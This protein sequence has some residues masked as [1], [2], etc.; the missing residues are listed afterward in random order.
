M[1]KKTESVSRTYRVK[2]VSDGSMTISINK[3][4]LENYMGELPVRRI[5]DWAIDSKM[6]DELNAAIHT[7]RELKI[8]VYRPITPGPLK[9]LMHYNNTI[10]S[11]SLSEIADHYPLLVRVKGSVLITG[12]GLGILPF[13][14]NGNPKVTSIDIVEI[15]PEV[16]RLTGPTLQHITQKVTIHSGNAFTWKPKRKFD[17]AWH[18][19][20]PDISADNLNEMKTLVDRYKPYAKWQGCWSK[21][22]CEMSVWREKFMNMLTH[23]KIEEWD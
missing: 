19:I 7:F 15:Q 13:L 9:R 10:M 8:G 11:N 21:E 1:S 18:D 6:I 5:N 4:A 2:R 12:L 16:I 17:Y 20:W 14:L 23:T 3:E 22:H